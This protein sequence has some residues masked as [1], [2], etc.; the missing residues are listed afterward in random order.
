MTVGLRRIQRFMLSV[1][2]GSIVNAQLVRLPVLLTEE[3]WKDQYDYSLIVPIKADGQDLNLLVD[4]GT[5]ELFFLSKGWLEESEGL[6]ACEASVYGCYQCTTDLCDAEVNEIEFCDGDCLSIVPLTGNL[7]IGGQEVPGVKFGLVQEYSGSMAPHASLGLA[8]QPEEDEDDYIPLLDQLVMK[9]VINSTDFSIVFNPGNLSEGELILGG[10]DP[11]R[12]RGPM[13]FVP[14]KDGYN[15]WT[16]GLKSIQVVGNAIP[17]PLTG[18]LPISIDS[19]T[20]GLYL[21]RKVF[22][23][24]VTTINSSLKPT[25]RRV[26]LKGSSRDIP[27]LRDCGDREFLPPLQLSLDSSDGRDLT[28]SVPQELYV[29]VYNTLAGPLC[30]LAFRVRMDDV[31]EIAIGLTLLRKYYVYLQYD[32]RRVGFAETKPK[33]KADPPSKGHTALRPN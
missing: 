26:D 1:V 9:R 11:G 22:D 16:V 18:D 15:T 4:T 6:G 24:L 12:Y 20:T 31:Q 29:E 25:G 30:A 21:P 13:S 19:G 27:A 32:Q 10:L 7:T 3:S 14:L 33:N 28:V 17:I 8:P 2:C 5:H 23:S